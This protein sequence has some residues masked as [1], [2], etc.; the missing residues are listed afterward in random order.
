[1][2][3]ILD[4]MFPPSIVEK[5]EGVFLKKVLGRDVERHELHLIET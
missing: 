3:D 4:S 5:M 2:G 1:M